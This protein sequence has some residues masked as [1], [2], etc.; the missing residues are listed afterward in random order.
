VSGQVRLWKHLNDFFRNNA[1]LKTK[2]AQP[3]IWSEIPKES[4][5]LKN[6]SIVIPVIATTRSVR[7]HRADIIVIDESCLIQDQTYRRDILP[8]STGD[9]AKVVLLSTPSENKGFFIDII[10]N[11]KRYGFILKQYSS[12]LCSWQTE[13][14]KRLK[15]TLTLEEYKREVLAEVPLESERSFFNIKMVNKC[16]KDI[17]SEPEKTYGSTILIGIDLGFG[18]PNPTVVTVVEKKKSK[19]KVIDQSIMKGLDYEKLNELFKKYNPYKI[20]VDSKPVELVRILKEGCSQYKGRMK[21]IDAML[22]KKQ[23][24]TQLQTVI[25]SQN[26]NIPIGFI[27]LKLEFGRYHL[28]K[29]SGDNRIDSLAL[30]IFESPLTEIETP[31]KVFGPWSEG[32]KK[33]YEGE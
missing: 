33:Y 29:R 16:F 1:D 10:S 31:N 23:A 3:G 4:F 22:Y 17:S 5:S 28:K 24:L 18:L 20:K 6:G 7:G 26:I 2:L 15:A 8:C 19:F 25:N 27:E 14:N 9:L 32:Y 21:F 11:P 12:E 13:S 30:A